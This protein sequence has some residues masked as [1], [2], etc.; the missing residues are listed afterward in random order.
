MD[1]AP[2]ALFVSYTGVLGGAERILLDRAAALEGPVAVACPGGPLAEAARAA[3][4]EVVGLRA[5]RFELRAT[6]RDRLAGPLRLGAQSREVRRAIAALRPRC[7]VAWNMRGL[8]AAAGA[9]AALRPRRPLVFAQNELLPSPLVGRAVR[10]AARRA[11]AVVALSNAIALDLD[12]SGRLG[13]RTSVIHPGVDLERFAPQPLPAE[14][15]V[16]VLGAIVHWK[17][18]E[19]ALDAFDRAAREEPGLRLRI[20]GAPLGEA[21]DGLLA[22]LRR[23]AAQP[24]FAGRVEIAGEAEDSAAALAGSTS[25]L[26]CADREPFGLVMAEALAAGRPVVAPRAGGALEIVDESCGALYEPGDAAEAARALVDVVG[27]SPELGG[28]ARA[29]AEERFDGRHAGRRFAELIDEL[30]R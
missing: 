23:R 1:S 21:G 8:L 6:A 28:A 30:C 27:G 5:R 2:Q 18:P 29:R 22:T 3:D 14:P 20:V 13:D 16:L 4:L 10:V 19:L 12:P 15:V 25:L 17:R 11:D 9:M 7:V 24:D 26:H